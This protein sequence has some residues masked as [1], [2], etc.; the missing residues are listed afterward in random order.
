MHS[1]EL[2]SLARNI[3]PDRALVLEDRFRAWGEELTD[4]AA[5]ATAVVAAFP[6]FA[7]LADARPSMFAE[8]SSEGWRSPRTRSGLLA[9]ISVSPVSRIIPASYEAAG[10]LKSQTLPTCFEQLKASVSNTSSDT[11]AGVS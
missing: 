9:T 10:G 1:S 8:L 7:Q 11:M 3:D 2:F 5:L 4:A 6:A